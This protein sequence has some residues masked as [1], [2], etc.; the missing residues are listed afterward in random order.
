MY[1]IDKNKDYY[2][3]YSYIY[4]VDK[5]VV[6][7][8]R[9]STILDNTALVTL[10]EG[11]NPI[12][13]KK[14]VRF[15]LLEVG[16]VQYLIK[17]FNFV[18]ECK[19]FGPEIKDFSV[20]LVNTFTDFKHRFTTPIS[21]RGVNIYQYFN[22]RTWKDPDKRYSH[23]VSGKYDEVIGRLYENTI[24]NPIISSTKLTGLLDVQKVWIELQTYISS[25]DNDKDCST[26][27]TDVERAE[28]HGFDKKTS[29]RNPIK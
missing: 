23:L 24:E 11:Y 16:Y 21:I 7:D 18:I 17:L 8:R 9:G 1:I 3:Y 14:S 20:E 12:Q 4:G 26:D 2:D 15:I 13:D 25:L 22:W 5:K 6:Y 27:M 10:S 19:L 29:F 28:I